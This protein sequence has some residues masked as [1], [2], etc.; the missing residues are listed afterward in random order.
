[1][2]KKYKA[3]NE[4]RRHKPKRHGPKRG[5]G[6]QQQSWKQEVPRFA[7]PR[8]MHMVLSDR[9]KYVLEKIAKK[10]N[11]IAKELLILPNKL[12][13]KFEYSYIDL[14]GR[15]DTLSYL[16]NGARDTA[17]A[18][19][20][21]SPKRQHSKVYKTI[22]TVFGS[23]YTKTDVTKFVSM[24]KEVYEQGPDKSDYPAR[25]KNT[26]EQLLKKIIEDTKSDKLKWNKE[27]TAGNMTRYESAVKIT[28]MKRL[29]FCF[30]HFDQAVKEESMSF[31]TINFYNDLGKTK[32][33]QRRW[34]QT[35]QFDSIANNFIP[36]FKEKYKITVG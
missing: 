36:A 9:F 23:K 17:E 22:K 10:G 12:D 3:F 34:I 19:R 21:K 4:A 28:E 13:A 11:A 25:G 1:M 7:E 2:L 18:D 33:D 35:F 30:F 26:D 29:V 5:G 24:F 31:L 32:D 16:P 8:G 20:F 15:G 27:E 6:F 14:T